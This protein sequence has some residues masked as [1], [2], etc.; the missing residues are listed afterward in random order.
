MDMKGK[1][2]ERDEL[3]CRIKQVESRVTGRKLGEGK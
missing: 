2:K 1:R 3:G